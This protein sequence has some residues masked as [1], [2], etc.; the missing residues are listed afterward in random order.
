MRA[1]LASVLLLAGVTAGPASAQPA[2]ASAQTKAALTAL[3]RRALDAI[4]RRD[5]AALAAIWPAQYH[6]TLAAGD[7][8]ID[9]SRAERMT[10]IA[11]STD[12]IRTLNL[13]NCQFEFFGDVAVAGCWLRQQG[14]ATRTGDWTGIFSTVVFRR[15]PRGRWWIIRNHSS[16]NRLA[17]R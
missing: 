11:V 14:V 1:A 12:S 13:E 17:K 5:T 10:M 7:S 2:P 6:F 15:D 3:Y 4:Q 16:V 9:L 8:I